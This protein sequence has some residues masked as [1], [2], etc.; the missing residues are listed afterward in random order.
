MFSV[1]FNDTATTEIY[2]LSLHDA[3]PIWS[4]R[5]SHSFI[6]PCCGEPLRDG[7]L[8]TSIMLSPVVTASPSSFRH[9]LLTVQ[10]L[11][12]SPDFFA[13][14]AVA[15]SSLRTA[16]CSICSICGRSYTARDSWHTP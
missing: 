10:L 5:I 1:F 7:S 3:L 13:G 8:P 15:A 6:L 14:T 11:C 9:A 4:N 16:G 12:S 2:T